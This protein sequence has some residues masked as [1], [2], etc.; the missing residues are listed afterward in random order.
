[1]QFKYKNEIVDTCSFHKF[2]FKMTNFVQNFR[3]I[4]FHGKKIEFQGGKSSFC[5]FSKIEFL[6]K[7][8]KNKPA[9]AS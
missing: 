8:T 7:R 2:D 4:E 5:I 3:K 9:K 6:P 1:M